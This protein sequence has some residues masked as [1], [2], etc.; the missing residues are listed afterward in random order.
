[1]CLTRSTHSQKKRRSQDLFTFSFLFFSFFFRALRLDG[2]F[3][4]LTGTKSA[5]TSRIRMFD[6]T[7]SRGVVLRSRRI[8]SQ[9]RNCEEKKSSL[10]AS[11]RYT[12]SE[13][14]ASKFSEKP[15]PPNYVSSSVSRTDLFSLT[16]CTSIKVLPLFT[17]KKRNN[18]SS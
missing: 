2:P 15:V 10:R 17:K 12:S 1:M 13:V 7:E 3:V 4:R 16:N 14:A 11:E 6:K 8:N 5:S 9:T 18:L